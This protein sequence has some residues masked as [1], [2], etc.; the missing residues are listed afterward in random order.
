[1]F[2]GI[3]VVKS[4]VANEK[5]MGNKE[6]EEKTLARKFINLETHEKKILN[7]KEIKGF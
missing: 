5:L 1:V 7:T 4:L 3:S 6:G 2:D